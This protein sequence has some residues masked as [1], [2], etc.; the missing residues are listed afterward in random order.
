[1]ILDVKFPFRN[2]AAIIYLTV[3]RRLLLSNMI[4]P[5]AGWPYCVDFMHIINKDGEHVATTIVQRVINRPR[6][7]WN[8]PGG[9]PIAVQA[10]LM[11]CTQRLFLSNHVGRVP[12][13]IHAVQTVIACAGL[14]GL[15][16]LA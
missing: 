7:R 12:I 9:W 16:R 11:N 15:V 6:V 8:F 3:D 10:G 2:A 14:A 5:L 4:V 1:M 13:G